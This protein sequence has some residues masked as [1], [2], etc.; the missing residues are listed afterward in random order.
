[1]EL[2]DEDTDNAKLLE[3][4]N[5]MDSI[6]KELY[7]VKSWLSKKIAEQKKSEET[8]PKVS[9]NQS[10]LKVKKLDVPEFSG[11]IRDYPSFKRDY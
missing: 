10:G 2:M 9:G 7:D 11:Q 4:Q 6:Y 5:Y 3:L 8:K 1:M